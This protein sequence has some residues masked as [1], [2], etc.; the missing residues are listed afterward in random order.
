MR[1]SRATI[2]AGNQPA[3]IG[4][5]YEYFGIYQAGAGQ[6]EDANKAFQYAVDAFERIGDKRLWEENATLLSMV[7]TPQGEIERSTQLWE[8]LYTIG[9]H[10]GST[11]TQCWSLLGQAEIAIL[12]NQLQTALDLLEK[13]KPL[14]DEIGVGEKI[15]HQGLLAQAYWRHGNP[16][17]AEQAAHVSLAMTAKATPVNFYAREGYAGPVEVYL[18]MLESKLE[19][20]ALRKAAWKSARSLDKF[21]KVFPLG[22]SRALTWHGVYAWL[23]GDVDKAHKLWQLSLA[24]AERLGI[25]YDRALA[26]F[27][28]GRHLKMEDPARLQ[29]LQNALALFDQL[30]ATYDR[31]VVQSELDQT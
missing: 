10:R 13:A 30:G 24:A 6:L 26:Q 9:V 20:G 16:H 15:W 5:I 18:R 14:A 19:N 8:R 1:L 22:Q 28:I 25:P 31:D 7:L 12:R 3:E 27:E 29:Y 21:A 17:L 2:E 11:N 23:T 4:E